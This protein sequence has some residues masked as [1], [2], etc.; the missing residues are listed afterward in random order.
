MDKVEHKA[1]RTL[2]EAA[3][4]ATASYRL[5]SIV[6]DCLR[7]LHPHGAD[8]ILRNLGDRIERERTREPIGQGFT[9]DDVLTATIADIQR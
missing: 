7:L 4:A 6:V 2:L 1:A 3:P 8:L 5:E 9:P